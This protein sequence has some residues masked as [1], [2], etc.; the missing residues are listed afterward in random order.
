MRLIRGLI[1]V[2]VLV[3]LVYVAV[4]V[5]LGKRTLWE[6]LKAIASSQ[7]SKELARGVKEKA[8]QMTRRE[9]GTEDKLTEE[10]RRQLRK[11]IHKL[12]PKKPEPER[13]EE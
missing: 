2:V 1:T 4:M 12:S 8:Q 13:D 10:E 6:H 7:E 3:A 11:L 9:G 5:P